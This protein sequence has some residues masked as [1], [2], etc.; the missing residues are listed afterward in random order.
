MK[1]S[2]FY[3]FIILLLINCLVG[4]SIYAY[5]NKSGQ[6]KVDDCHLDVDSDKVSS[7]MNKKL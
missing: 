4:I 2:E 5:L 1:K 6:F 7:V 3:T